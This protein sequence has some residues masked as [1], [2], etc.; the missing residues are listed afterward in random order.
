LQDAGA[1]EEI[2][3]T[4]KMIEAGAEVIAAFD[5]DYDTERAAAK[6]PY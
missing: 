6:R 2:E 4:P 5:R 1:P 3:I